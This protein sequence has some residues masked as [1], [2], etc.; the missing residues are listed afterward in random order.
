[1][2]AA[3]VEAEAQLGLQK[4]YSYEV[5]NTL[6]MLVT[7]AGN[8]AFAQCVRRELRYETPKLNRSDNEFK[9][10]SN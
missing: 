5:V 4:W 2:T 8:I 6:L 10:N 3:E 7:Y 9:N 1:M